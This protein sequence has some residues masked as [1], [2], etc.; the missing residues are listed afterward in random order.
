L[1]EISCFLITTALISSSATS[2]N[3]IR[4]EINW[5]DISM[6]PATKEDSSVLPSLS[7]F[8]FYVRLFDILD[9]SSKNLFTPLVRY[10]L[11][12]ESIINPFG[13]ISFCSLN[14]ILRLP[15]SHILVRFPD[16]KTKSIFAKNAAMKPFGYI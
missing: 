5:L 13:K 3:S 2:T 8:S 9:I 11:F 10:R 14:L 12:S 6:P 15:V 4:S 16:M 1:A 7:P